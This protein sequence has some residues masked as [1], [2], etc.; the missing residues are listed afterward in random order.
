MCVK[1]ELGSGEI[2]ME[3]GDKVEVEEVKLVI[4]YSDREQ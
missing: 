1:G 2:W 4:R 3:R